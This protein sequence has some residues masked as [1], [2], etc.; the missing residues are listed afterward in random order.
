MGGSTGSLSRKRPSDA[1]DINQYDL[2]WIKV[3]RNHDLGRNES[4][5]IEDKA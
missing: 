1:I 5:S 3:K 4:M 2:I